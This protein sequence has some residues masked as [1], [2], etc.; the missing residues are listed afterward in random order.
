[1]LPEASAAEAALVGDAV[2][3]PARSLLGVCA[4]I[5]GRTLLA[6]LAASRPVAGDHATPLPDLADVRG[7]EQAKR[8][9][10]IAAAGAHSLL[11]L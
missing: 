9:L 10:T 7:Q 11:I 6:P 4:H 8:A 1:M 3:Y 2:V 5:M